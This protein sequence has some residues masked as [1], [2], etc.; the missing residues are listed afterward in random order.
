MIVFNFATN[1]FEIF[2]PYSPQKAFAIYKILQKYNIFGD[3]KFYSS[4]WL[5]RDKK[6]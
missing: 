6:R 2:S 5:V 4:S 3:N 1:V